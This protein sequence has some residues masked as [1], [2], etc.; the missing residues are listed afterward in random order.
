MRSA[1]K[2]VVLECSDNGLMSY[3]L[4]LNENEIF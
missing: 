3:Q 4:N 2:E 1:L